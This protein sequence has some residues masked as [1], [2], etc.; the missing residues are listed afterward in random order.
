MR[1]ADG[2][3]HELRA[4]LAGLGGLL[5]Y[6]VVGY[7]AF[8]YSLLDA[9]YQTVLVVTT[10][11]FLAGEVPGGAEKL[12]SASLAAFGVAVFLASLAIFTAALADGRIRQ[13]S[14][15]RRMQ[16]Q[17]DQMKDHYIICA[18]GRVGRAVAREFEGERVP[19]VVVDRLEDLEERMQSDGVRYVI[20]D[21]TSEAVLQSVG[22]DRARGLISAVDSD[23]DNV[24][25]TLTA[26]SL[27]A[28]L[29]IVA[30]ASESAAADRLYRAGAD[31]VISPYV[32]SGR[33]MAMLSLR[34]RV[35]D[36]LEI[37]GRGD[38]KMRLE[39]LQVEPG[40]ALV[41]MS[42]GEACEGATPLVVRRGTTVLPRPTG[43]EVL[44][45]GD[46][47]VLLGEPRE[48]RSVEG[49]V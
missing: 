17:I 43:D 1:A 35:L 8:G 13:V 48:L 46:V 27:R 49:E 24:Y 40:S 33:H 32:S 14:R 4:P 37:T 44:Q 20:G 16:R 29:F 39:E 3:L 11:G 5:A 25:I 41:G 47:I 42:L 6:G 12:F 30:R 9:V 28:N 38:E 34:P 10:V 19:F 26:R 21:P 31:R 23:A 2:I 7:V 36:Y 45:P 15:R 18:Y 22:I